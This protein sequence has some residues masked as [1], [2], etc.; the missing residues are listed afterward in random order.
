MRSSCKRLK[1]QR[2]R[3]EQAYKLFLIGPKRA[4]L[5]QAIL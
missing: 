1:K 5:L 4:K 3:D 2:E